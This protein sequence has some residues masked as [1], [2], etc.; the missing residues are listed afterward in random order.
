MTDRIIASRISRVPYD[1]LH[2]SRLEPNHQV[3]NDRPE[4]KVTKLFGF[5]NAPASCR[6]DQWRF[7]GGVGVVTRLLEVV[8]H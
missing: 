7:D 6:H 8:D 5:G 2:N 4:A 3:S 1:S